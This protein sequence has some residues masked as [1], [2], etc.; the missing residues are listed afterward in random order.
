MGKTLSETTHL[1]MDYTTI[2][3]LF[4][5]IWGDGLWHCFTKTQWSRGPAI[6]TL[7]TSADVDTTRN[8]HGELMDILMENVE[9]H[10]SLYIPSGKLT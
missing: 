1:G 7:D 10:H 9:Q 8:G 4:L 5:V 3:H 6:A 2:Y